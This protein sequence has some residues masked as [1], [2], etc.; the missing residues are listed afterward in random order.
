MKGG[1]EDD[2]NNATTILN[3]ARRAA[4]YIETALAETE[5][6]LPTVDVRFA[7]DGPRHNE[8]VAQFRA[9]DNRHLPVDDHARLVEMLTLAFELVDEE[10]DHDCRVCMYQ[11]DKWGGGEKVLDFDYFM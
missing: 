4:D 11:W 10:P 6:L 7:A 3:E 8:Q 2:M 9:W 5:R 1:T